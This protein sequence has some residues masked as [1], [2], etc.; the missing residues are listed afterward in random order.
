MRTGLRILSSKLPG[1][2]LRRKRKGQT[3]AEVPTQEMDNFPFLAHN[4]RLYAFV[5]CIN[6][7]KA[8]AN[9]TEGKSAFFWENPKTDL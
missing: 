5:S 9:A 4:S 3:E 6:I 1:S 8:T 2:H 7:A